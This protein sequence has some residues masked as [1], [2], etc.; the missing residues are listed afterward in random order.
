MSPGPAPREATNGTAAIISSSK[1]KAAARRLRR[2]GLA[3]I[4]M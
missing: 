1:A 2:L 4:T 3:S